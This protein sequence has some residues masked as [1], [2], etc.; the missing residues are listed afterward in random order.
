MNRMVNG[1]AIELTADE[2]AAIVAQWAQVAASEA[3][4]LAAN[5]YKISRTNA[6]PALGD[7]LDD[8]WHAIDSGLPIDKTST[9]Y[10]ARQAIK[11]QYPKP[12]T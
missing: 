8:L 3:A 7:Q 11:L 2:E 6:Y 4:D 9:F 10:L 1:V 12:T 5:G